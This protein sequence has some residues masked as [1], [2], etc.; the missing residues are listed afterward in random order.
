MNNGDSVTTNPQNSN[1]NKWIWIGLGAA[2]LFC[3]CALLVAFLIFRQAG[4]AISQG[5]KTDPEE[6]S[7]AA[8]EIVDYDLP[9]GYEERIAMDMLVYSMVM[10][11][12]E[13][14]QGNEPVIMLAQFSPM[15]GNDKQLEQQMVQAF[16]Q[17]SGTK[18]LDMELVEVK[19]MTIRDEDTS[20][21]IYEGTDQ[22]GNSIRQ[23]ITTFSGKDGTVMLLIMGNIDGWDDDLVDAFI[24]SIR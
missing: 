24:E 2:L 16:E 4:R 18:G 3:C 11:G 8:H 22:Y 20:V 7:Q 5:V 15:A 14:Y 21:G 6:A 10:I 13:S 9:D 12:P 1:N 23:L 17:Q 19:D